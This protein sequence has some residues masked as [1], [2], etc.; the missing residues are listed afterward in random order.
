MAFVAGIGGLVFPGRARGSRGEA[1]DVVPHYRT[2]PSHSG[3][4][5]VAQRRGDAPQEPLGGAPAEPQLLPRSCYR[6]TPALQT[7]ER[8]S[9]LWLHRAPLEQ[10]GEHAGGWHCPFWHTRD[11]QSPLAPQGAPWLQFG[12]QL[13]GAHRLLVH[14]NDEQLPLSPQMAPCRQ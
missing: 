14:T 3:Y 2:A 5:R 10:V 11:R 8:Q 7:D 9:P 6:H 4:P 12:E 1:V 13:D